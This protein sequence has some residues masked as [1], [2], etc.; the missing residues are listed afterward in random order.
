MLDS[1]AQLAADFDEAE[2]IVGAASSDN[3][4]GFDLIEEIVEGLLAIFGRLADG[5]DPSDFR[6]RIG[7]FDLYADGGGF[8]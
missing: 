8:V 1:P 3:D 6:S 4:N 2:G 5:V 7:D